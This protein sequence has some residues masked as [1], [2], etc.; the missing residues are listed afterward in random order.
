MDDI[1]Y[2]TGILW[3][4]NEVMQENTWLMCLVTQSCPI[5]CDPMDRSPPGSSVHG[6]L[7]SKNTGVGCHALLQGIVPT[8]RLNP[9]LLRCRRTLYQLSYQGSAHL[10][11]NRCLIMLGAS[12]I[13]ELVKNLPAIPLPLVRN[14]FPA[15]LTGP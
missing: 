4:L 15:S 10:V 12:L 2:F 9:G 5:L 8:R 7:L 3:T 11:Y 14:T 1:I 13:A 6:D